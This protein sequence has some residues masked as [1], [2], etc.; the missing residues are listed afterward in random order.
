MSN[1]GVAVA[2]FWQL[3]RHRKNSEKTKLE[4]SCKSKSL[5]IQLSAVLSHPE[6]QHF[7]TPQSNVTLSK[8]KSPSQLRRQERR[9]QE[10]LRANLATAKAFEEEARENAPVK[11]VV[12][13]SKVSNKYPKENASKDVPTCEE[14]GK[15]KASAEKSIVKPSYKEA[16]S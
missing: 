15:P 1:L 13:K 8:N 9:W 3:A 10:A 16:E 5:H 11:K 14:G 2:T 7:L 4:L 12:E 6:Q